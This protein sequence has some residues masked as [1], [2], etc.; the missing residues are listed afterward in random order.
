MRLLL[1]VCALL[2]LCPVRPAAA[3]DLYKASVPLDGADEAAR[4]NAVTAAFGRVLAQVAGRQAVATLAQQPAGRKAAQSAL[5]AFGTKTGEDGATLLEAQFD[6]AAVR[7]FLDERHVAAPA[8]RRPTLLLWLLLEGSPAAWVG[9]DE[10]P[11]LA[12][13][14]VQSAAARGLP[15]LLP[16]L[17]LDERAMLPAALDPADPASVAALD[18]ASARYRPDGVLFGRLR[19][20]DGR[21]RADLRLTLSGRE[22]AVWSANGDSAPAAIDAA[23]DRVAGQLA[24]APAPGGPL[25]PVQI[26]VAGIDEVTAYARVWEHL[27]GVPGLRRLR[28]VALGNGKAV[29][30]FE[31][32]GGEAALAGRVEPGAPFAHSADSS[33]YRFQP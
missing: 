8:D 29:F 23:L 24:P 2:A 10:P 19:E 13:E 1:F 7:A 33:G 12:G 28:P 4:E 18:T 32:A 9:A 20:A 27:T 25:A 26:T 15:L 3:L 11:Q 14:L 22:D 16:L 31:L 30:A 6:P 5:S 21:W 17:D